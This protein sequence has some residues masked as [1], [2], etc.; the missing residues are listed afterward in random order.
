MTATGTI[1][2]V[3]EKRSVSTVTRKS[4]KEHSNTISLVGY[5]SNNT[6]PQSQVK[7]KFCDDEANNQSV[8]AA[9]ATSQNL[10]RKV[11]TNPQPAK[12]TGTFHAQTLSHTRAI[13]NATGAQTCTPGVAAAVHQIVPRNNESTPLSSASQ[14]PLMVPVNASVLEQVV[15][16]AAFGWE[17]LNPEGGSRQQHVID[18]YRLLNNIEVSPGNSA[19]SLLCAT[20]SIYTPGN[21]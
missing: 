2:G 7:N 6:V 10:K 1:Q 8:I 16:L 3:E 13:I 18:L 15:N 5:T 4:A 9:R 11:K 20:S 21:G 12:S 19:V 17:R 14:I